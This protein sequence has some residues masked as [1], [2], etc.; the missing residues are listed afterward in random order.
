MTNQEDKPQKT[1]RV[2]RRR[3]SGPTP[4][5]E[6]KRAEAPQRRRPGGEPSEQPPFQAESGQPPTTTPLGGLLGGAGRPMNLRMMLIL[7][8]ILICMAL[9]GIPLGLQQSGQESEQPALDYPTESSSIF[10]PEEQPTQ[11]PTS[12]KRPTNT[13][14]PATGAVIPG[15]KSSWLVMLYQDADDKI[16]EQDIYIDLN[17]VERV[18]SSDQVQIVAQVDRFQGGFQGDGNWYSTRRYYITQDDDLNTVHSDL[19]ENLGEINMSDGS[20]LKDFVIWAIENYPASK[21]VLILSDHGLGWPGGW[22]D[23]DSRAGGD[24]NIPLSRVLGDQLYLNELDQALSEIRS[25]TGINQ[26]EV[27][28]MDACLM[29][30]LEVFTALAPHAR[31]AIASQETEPAL[32]WAYTSFL[33]GLVKNPEMDSE[34]LIRLVVESYV[35]EDQR[36]V[37]P[38]ARAEFMRQGSPMGGLFQLLGAPPPEQL[39]QQ[40]ESNITLTAVDLEKIENLN[41]QVNTLS[42]SLMGIAQEKIARARTYAQSFTSIFGKEVPPSYIDLGNFVQFLQKES[43]SNAISQSA[44]QVLKALKEAV[45]AEKH[46][47]QKP[48]ATGI[49]IYFPNSQLYQNAVAGPQSYTNIARRFAELSLWDDYLAY[50]YTGRKFEPEARQAVVPASGLPIR[51]PGAG[52]IEISEI[53]KSRDWAAPGQPVTLKADI[54][55]QNIGYVYLFTGFYDQSSNSIFVADLDYLASPDTRQ[56]EGIYYPD[57]GESG[58]FTLEFEWEPLMFAITD[59]QSSQIALFSPQ[60]YGATAEEATYTVEGIYTF[61]DSGESRQ[62]VLLFRNGFLRQVFGFTGSEEAGAPR[63]IIPQPGDQFT[64]LEKWL[65]LDSNGNIV[66]E[67]F[68][69]GGI[70]TFTEQTFQWQELDA[71]VGNYIVGIIVEDLDGNQYPAYTSVTVR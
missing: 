33:S 68:Q 51:G 69:E 53:R 63:E 62:A 23:S 10:L 65:D 64:I 60:S 41:K 7:I 21:Y 32:G 37:D 52:A 11:Q 13:P 50:H 54:R 31:Y 6:R 39:A 30:H 16:L 58:E 28:G 47:P 36:L 17:E 9:V 71:A 67:A 43:N 18:G 8:G 40:L 56:V 22:S 49:S 57:W 15:Q 48:G 44:S 27:I 34:E 35:K 1:I 29:G 55:G 46:G 59:G 25:Q 66:Q 42:I 14:R 5:R 45:V 2:E 26:F 3:P 19:I 70:L 38:V 12:T 24:V 20:A 61:G 4:P